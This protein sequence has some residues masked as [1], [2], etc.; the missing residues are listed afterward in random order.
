MAAELYYR[1]VDQ[2]YYEL[3]MTPCN[4]ELRA[5]IGPS[6]REPY[7]EIFRLLRDRLHTTKIYI[8]QELSVLEQ[9]KN[10]SHTST[11]APVAPSETY[12]LTGAVNTSSGASS[13]SSSSS[14]SSSSSSLSSTSSL[15]SMNPF[16]SQQISTPITKI[17]EILQPLELCYRS[18]H[19]SGLGII[20]DGKLLDVLRRV[21]VFGLSMFQLDIRQ[22][23]TQHTRA[24]DA[25]TK[26][27]GFPISY[28]KMTEEQRVEFLLSELSSKRPLIPPNF[29]SDH[30]VQNALQEHYSFSEIGMIRDVI[31][32]FSML[33]EQIPDTLN[34]YII[35]M[36]KMPSDILAVHLLQKEARVTPLRR[37]VPLFETLDDL[38]NSVKTMKTLFSLPE[39]LTRIQG[40]QEIMVSVS[41]C[42]CFDFIYFIIIFFFLTYNIIE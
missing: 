5:V 10:K 37:V 22:E 12:P 13:S 41:V 29:T 39:Y 28:A 11:L 6:V 24:L 30:N 40:F 9:R 23:S 38:A 33:H 2:L 21:H 31:D 8:K 42:L 20:A 15:S 17:N 26:Y 18:L 36:T 7:R 34:A 14:L 32:T 19:Q 1:E 25:V 35:S 16:H 27:L 4:E 3:S